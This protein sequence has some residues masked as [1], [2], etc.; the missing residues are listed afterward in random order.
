VSA[1]MVAHGC[2]DCVRVPCIG[3]C[4]V[5]QPCPACRIVRASVLV[6]EGVEG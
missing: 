3:G 4:S 2:A 1:A 5:A 6:C